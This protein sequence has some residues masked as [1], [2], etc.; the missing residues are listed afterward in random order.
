MKLLKYALVAAGATAGVLV[1]AAVAFAMLFDPNS[2]KADV[3]RIV[4]EEK[5]RT[6]KLE[7]EVKL[8]FFPTLGVSLGRTTLT[9]KNSPTLFA[10][11][12]SAHVS[13]GV[14]PLLSGRAVVDEVRVAGL[15]AALVRAK[16]G[17]LNA[18]DL[19]EA[20]T[21]GGA[22]PAGEPVRVS[23]DV[24]GVRI[25]RA[26][27]D[28]R[29]EKTGRQITLSDL[30]LTTGRIASGTP[31][32]VE[33]S[34]ALKGRAPAVDAKARLSAGYRFDSRGNSLSI[35]RIDA[36]L[37][38]SVAELTALEATLK[39]NFAAGPGAATFSATDLTLESRG[40]LGK[41]RVE[42]KVTAPAVS[43][44]AGKTAG[45]SVGAE[46][47]VNTGGDS[48]QGVLKLTGVEGNAATV[49]VAALTLDLTLTSPSLAQK[50]LQVP[51]RG[52]LRADLAKQTVAAD[53]TAQFDESSMRAKLGV[54]RL[55]PLA[56]VF[57][58]D[59]DRL[60]VDKYLPPGSDASRSATPPVDPP[61]DLSGL[62]GLQ[63][64]G[65]I[66]IGAL[67]L[68]GIK[69][70]GVKAEVRAADGRLEVSP[71][72]AG[73][74]GGTLNGALKA[75]ADGNRIA[76]R[77]D[78]TGVSIGPLLRDLAGR[79]ALEGR[80]NVVFD[81]TAAG[82]TQGAMKKALA[83][84]A[85]A[86]LKDGSVKGINLAETLRKAKA[87]IGSGTAQQQVAKGGEQT[88]FSELSA[89][90]TIKDGVAHNEDLQAKAP[91][92]RLTG[93]GDI[94]IGNSRLNYVAKASVVATAQGQGGADLAHLKGLTIPV[95]LSGP[96]E[97][98]SYEID[99]AAVIAGAAT[100]KVRKSVED[101][102]KDAIGGRLKGLFGR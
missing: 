12:D 66:A 42:M 94:D 38:G 48:V 22:K 8:A 95:K 50:T 43:I 30:T 96:F 35:D 63:T 26:K 23:F 56:T 13:V 2:F 6:L 51:L 83:G 16:D 64:S 71:H 89:S 60:N 18:A 31:G 84:S 86:Q 28:Y 55:E 80:G 21:T 19:F 87:A 101:K 41:D 24:S 36:R 27:L 25:E 10:T 52:A 46:F 39:G 17:R 102:V 5:Q 76:I 33:L 4:K 93:A 78:L 82:A 58:I 90:F 98:P 68:S 85:R 62:K 91:L 11:L 75:N 34:A 29:D 9:E 57:D 77:Q 32:I 44:A 7:G 100:E 70:T 59:I 14:L 81:L 53:V 73:L 69:L 20:P 99:Y 45:A 65:K 3:E 15:S 74:Y 88:D 72:S 47:K 40:A 97:A 67:T 49:S 1:L 37:D 54:V 61:V 79:D 92:F